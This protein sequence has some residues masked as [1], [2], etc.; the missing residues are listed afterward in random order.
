[1]TY[2]ANKNKSLVICVI[3]RKNEYYYK[4]IFQHKPVIDQYHKLNNNAIITLDKISKEDYQ[5]I[6]LKSL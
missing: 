3:K 2:Y 4:Y 5:N 1:M 6:L